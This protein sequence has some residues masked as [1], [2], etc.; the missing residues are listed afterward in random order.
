MAAGPNRMNTAVVLRTTAGLA[1]YLADQGWSG[2]PVVVGHDA[3]HHSSGSRPATAQVLAATGFPVH[4]VD[5]PM[6]TPL[7]AFAVTYLG[8]CA[9]V[10][11]TASHNPPAD[12]GYKVYL[13][14]G[15]QIVPPADHDIAAAIAAVPELPTVGSRPTSVLGDDVVAAYVDGALDTALHAGE[16]DV[17]IVYTPMHGVGRDIVLRAFAA[18]GF[19]PPDVV[20]QQAEPD[21]DFPTVAFPNPEEPGSDGPGARPGPPHRGRRAAGQR[22]RRRPAGRGGAT[23]RWRVAAADRR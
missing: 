9:G 17:R 2:R 16:R 22:P 21:P 1:A 18:A 19:R 3:R 4:L 13:G 15:A 8:C 12:N 14:D 11:I 20:P 10:Q 5:R 23:A 7:V 6:P